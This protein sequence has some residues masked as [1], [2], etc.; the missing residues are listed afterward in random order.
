[1]SF[2]NGDSFADGEGFSG[3]PSGGALAKTLPPGQ[4]SIVA[5]A[6][7]SLGETVVFCTGD[8]G[9]PF[10]HRTIYDFQVLDCH[11]ELY[12]LSVHRGG[13]V[14]ICNVASKCKEYT[15]SGYTMLTSLY[16][17]YRYDGLSVLAFPCNQFGSG[18]PGAEEDIAETISCRFPQLGDIDFPIM[19][20]TEVNGDRELPLYSFLKS[21]IRGTIGQTSVR[22]NFTTFLV[23]ANGIPNA[24]FAPGTSIEVIE[25]RV[26]ALLHSPPLPPVAIGAILM[27]LSP[28]G[29]GGDEDDNGGLQMA[30]HDAFR[31]TSALF[32]ATAK[33]VEG[34]EASN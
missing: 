34:M 24:R 33:T 8:P 23:D 17:R 21:C 13:P 1:M 25:E 15:Q 4:S 29:H 20:K 9:S 16:H 27:E 30:L 32:S 31:S 14:L 19:A 7:D 2:V 26:K 22:W 28:M 6:P 3:P 18:E 11:H 12:D 5:D 10:R